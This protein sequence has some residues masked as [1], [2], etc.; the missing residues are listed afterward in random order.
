[1]FSND[2]NIETIAQLVEE[3][4]KYAT[5][6][7]EY[8]RLDLIEKTVKLLTAVTMTVILVALFLM[9]VTFLSFALAYA[10]APAMGHAWGFVIVGGIYAVLFILC[11][12][13]RKTWIERPLVK[14][15]ANILME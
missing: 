10:L 2:S 1:M 11:I 5:L 15:L 6:K 3:F 7:G 13:N 14:F 12:L 8:F 4:K 9:V